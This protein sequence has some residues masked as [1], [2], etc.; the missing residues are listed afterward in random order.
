[1]DI[2]PEQIEAM[3]TNLKEMSAAD[4][5]IL[6]ALS[7]SLREEETVRLATIPGSKNDQLW[8]KMAE[9]HWMTL[10]TPL[11]EH[12]ASKVYIVRREALEP[13]ETVLLELKR[14]ELPALFNELRRDIPSLIVPRVISAGGTPADVAVMLAGI[15][16]AT[17]RRWIRD[18]LHEEFLRTVFD[19]AEDLGREPRL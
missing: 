10:D 8:S 17:M 14:D 5:S 11:E 4:L 9:L 13:I 3:K 19:R 6:A 15:V 12:P 2:S 1:M 18:E 16:E 7:E